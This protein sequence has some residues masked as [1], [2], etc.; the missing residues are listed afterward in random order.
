MEMVYTQN[1]NKELE[2]CCNPCYNGDG[3][4]HI[5][6]NKL[7]FSIFQLF[8][9]SKNELLGVYQYIKERFFNRIY[10]PI[11][12]IFTNPKGE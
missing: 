2:E 11:C 8:F 4:H 7:F 12:D 10:Q 9:R 1:R 5:K 3:V 6:Y